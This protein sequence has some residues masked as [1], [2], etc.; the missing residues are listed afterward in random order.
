MAKEIER[1]F[2]VN[3]R[4]VL[5]GRRGLPI[6]QGYLAK[7]AMTVRVR[8]VGRAAFLTVKGPRV[9]LARDEF[10]YEIPVED[11]LTMLHG[12]CSRRL[13]TKTRYLVPH[14]RHVFEVDVFAGKLAG[15]VVAEVELQNAAERIDLPAWIGPEVTADR[16][17]GNFTLA[18]IDAPPEITAAAA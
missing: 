8:I 13:I 16:R 17:F 4:S 6:L 5:R 12:H 2:L 9:G 7:E 10:E 14:G 3:D 1:K 15:L 18:G 11:A